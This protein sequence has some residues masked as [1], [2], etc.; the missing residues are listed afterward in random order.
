MLG[1]A[2]I[3]L[4]ISESGSTRKVVFSGDLGPLHA[5]I[6]KEFE[7]FSDADTVFL[8]STYGDRDHR[9]FS[10]TVAEFEH[11]V[12]QAAREN[13]RMLV[14]TFAVGRAQLLTML[15]ADIFRRGK[16]NPFPIFLDSPMAIEAAK[17]LHRHPELFDSEMHAF[18]NNG[19]I[20]HDLR[21]LRCT[22]SAE[23]SQRIN[24]T[25][26]PC[27]VMAGAGMCN[28]GRILHHLR[29]NLWKPGTHV[30]IVGFQSR[31]SLGRRL[32]EGAREVRIFGEPIQVKAKIH[33]LGGFSA[34]AGQSDLLG[35]LS[36]LAGRRP[37]LFLTHGEDQARLA[38]AQKIENQFGLPAELPLLNTPIGL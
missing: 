9:S 30:I 4:L 2:S 3:Q 24:Q 29:H 11:I 32:I 12:E 35:W 7:P 34:H 1:S 17:V 28:A 22:A 14:P 38:L 16:V 10:Q 8:E 18:L 6:L 23:E 37:R 27:F 13:G 5:P 20:E 21:T 25:K 15:L 33:T 31:D 26:G 19:N 36:A